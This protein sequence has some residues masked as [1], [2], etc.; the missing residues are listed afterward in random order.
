MSESGI[1]S[2]QQR[3]E[4]RLQELS[5]AAD[6][7]CEKHIRSLGEKTAET[8]ET[9]PVTEATMRAAI[10][11]T[12]R[13]SELHARVGKAPSEPA[14]DEIPRGEETGVLLAH[15]LPVIIGGQRR[16]RLTAAAR[17][18][19]LGRMWEDRNFQTLL[20]SIAEREREPEIFRAI[21]GD[22]AWKA[23]A[24]L[25]AFLVGE[26]GYIHQAPPD[27]LRAA[28]TARVSLQECSLRH[29]LPSLD[30][31]QRALDYSELLEPLQILIGSQGGWNKSPESDRYAGREGELEN[32]NSFVSETAA[33][34]TR[35][36]VQRVADHIVG[37][38][39]GHRKAALLVVKARGGM[40]KSSL[41]AKFILQHAVR[42]VGLEDEATSHTFPFAY[43]DFDRPTLQGRDPRFLLLE[44]IRQVSLQFPEAKDRLDEIS[45]RVRAELNAPSTQSW[46]PHTELRDVLRAGA[47]GGNQPFLVVL[48]T[49]EVAQYDPLS[50]KAV[51]N[52]LIDLIGDGFPELRIVVVGRE[53]V[54]PGMLFL[55]KVSVREPLE[56]LPLN[57]ADAT[58]M[59]DKRG[60][61]LLGES[62]RSHWAER[63]AGSE[64][65]RLDRR[66]P[67]SIRVAVDLL[68]ATAP[69]S[70][71]ELCAKIE[72]VGEAADATFVGQLY[73][74]R[75]LGHLMGGDA[76]SKLA[77]QGLVFRNLTEDIAAGVLAPLC[78]LTEDE[79]RTAFDNLAREG[80]LV[81]E[82]MEPDG[83]R[84][85]RHQRD[86]RARTL[87]LMRRD[88]TEDGEEPPFFGKVNN[89]A[90]AYFSN[91][92]THS[93]L[94]GAEWLYHRLLHGEKPSELHQDWRD[95]YR[96]TLSDAVADFGSEEPAY[97]YLLAQT[98]S[99]L[100]SPEALRKMADWMLFEHVERVGSSLGAFDDLH[101]RPELIDLTGRKAPEPESPAVRS[102]RQTLLAKAG[103][104]SE[105]A[106]EVIPASPWAYQADFARRYLRARRPA[107][108]E[109]MIASAPSEFALAEDYRGLAQDLAWA[110]IARHPA[111]DDIDQK[112]A[113][114]LED[115]RS[116]GQ[117]LDR[118]ALGI[119]AIFGTR[120]CS[121]AVRQTI[122]SAMPDG[123][124]F[125]TDK[126]APV[127]L[128][129]ALSRMIGELLPSRSPDERIVPARAGPFDWMKLLKRA[130]QPAL[131][132]KV[133]Q[134][135]ARRRE[136]WT[137]P[138][139][140][141]CAR[142][143]A[144][145]TDEQL[146]P[147]FPSSQR[148]FVALMRRAE[149]GG[150]LVK[151]ARLVLEL[152]GDGEASR[153]L[154]QLLE[155][156][157]AW[158]KAIKGWLDQA[159][160]RSEVPDEPPK[161]GAIANKSDP[162]KG[163][164]G[165]SAERGGRRLRADISPVPAGRRTFQFSLVVESTDA[166]PLNPP[167]VFH[168]HDTFTPDTLHVHLV[169]GHRC[170]LENLRAW[171]AFAVGAQVR[172]DDG[173]WIALELDLSELPELPKK[174]RDL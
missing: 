99:R 102:A 95:E 160:N 137:T 16:L 135:F 152:S 140:Y 142:A 166:S 132:P 106:P 79:A 127:V 25:R 112:L 77:G 119:A 113:L 73:R 10:A 32:L 123:L 31:I 76:V 131:I 39:A 50:V 81:D 51:D 23:S 49:F 24:W 90:I 143:A 74:Q 35:G 43:L 128:P 45:E 149:A 42:Y 52:L 83:T 100:A 156:E 154:R 27:E 26:F 36:W 96:T 136:D 164:W 125:V 30:E 88:S 38:N 171:G 134:Y 60:K 37:K 118:G 174:F 124:A 107:S 22:P 61:S 15:S 159:E 3:L 147:Q 72:E 146:A 33:T 41:I 19:L 71:D 59:A 133:R 130:T 54:D 148:D 9:I 44:I 2:F 21:T 162:Q 62:W 141:A 46:N 104:W 48:D 138:F 173:E 11:D 167:V 13:L 144:H 98:S 65:G 150:E 29:S 55:A 66:E 93:P 8:P 80:W 120:S 153:D 75:V 5:A 97:V 68:M 18:D 165:G 157:A 109:K 139:G 114:C 53:D 129:M 20:H 115:L 58:E 168:L 94:A 70:R 28:S 56:I 47:G 12:F 170:K 103:C 158:S 122:V 86:L 82:R 78:R 121:P 67:L 116:D 151:T 14:T 63:I 101:T 117:G 69:E 64:E 108:E 126:V 172:G 1:L 85:L 92:K 163:R 17:A 87:P 169:E 111:Y 7:E 89:A 145:L 161:P 34:K 155:A 57:I 4:Q 110:A 6:A 84:V 105:Q 40:G 91:H